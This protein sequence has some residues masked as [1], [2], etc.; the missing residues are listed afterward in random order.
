MEKI[1]RLCTCKSLDAR[2][3]KLKRVKIT[4]AH[5]GKASRPSSLLERVSSD[6]FSTI[7]S[8]LPVKTVFCCLSLCSKTIDRAVVRCYQP[9]SLSTALGVTGPESASSSS[10][11]SLSPAHHHQQRGGGGGH[12]NGASSSSSSSLSTSSSYNDYLQYLSGLST[13]SRL[14]IL[15]ITLE[16]D[17]PVFLNFGGFHALRELHLPRSFRLSFSN[18]SMD[19]LCCLPELQTLHLGY[20]S[21]NH[22]PEIP[23]RIGMDMGERLIDLQFDTHSPLNKNV[24]TS[25]ADKLIK[26]KTLD[27]KFQWLYKNQID[28]LFCG[29][30]NLESLI[31]NSTAYET[32]SFGGH[33]TFRPTSDIGVK[34][35]TQTNLTSFECN[36]PEDELIVCVLKCMEVVRELKIHQDTLRTKTINLLS[37]EKKGEET[38]HFSLFTTQTFHRFEPA[39]L[40]T[41]ALSLPSLQHLSL[42]GGATHI[43]FEKMKPFFLSSAAN[44]LSF[45]LS[46]VQCTLDDS[47]LLLIMAHCSNL[48]H[49]DLRGARITD[50][51]AS[52]IPLNLPRLVH[53]DLNGCIN[54]TD[55]TVQSVL[56]GCHN[57]RYLDVSL[58]NQLTVL[59]VQY[60]LTYGRDLDCFIISVR[61]TRRQKRQQYLR[62][63][64]NEWGS[65]LKIV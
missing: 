33:T 26:L 61:T 13:F 20:I 14:H 48:T 25:L 50:E 11:S 59:T 46:R 5:T 43:T 35:W 47:N 49:L 10:S 9:T 42:S 7:L 24:L 40:K 64:F 21:R 4:S 19:A 8:F 44:L 60:V 63:V 62:Q 16:I 18:R 1:S 29:K 23:L 55:V 57:L 30:M 12:T 15:T 22:I 51:S 41:I 17:Q 2:K 36:S 34:E 37:D 28:A 52:V 53:L 65:T 3:K 6:V 56:S 27:I 32:R 45:R 38:T 58:C 39:R 54:I 31:L